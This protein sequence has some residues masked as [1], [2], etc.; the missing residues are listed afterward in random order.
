[1]SLQATWTAFKVSL[2]PYSTHI[3]QHLQRRKALREDTSL[4]DRLSQGPERGRLTAYGHIK[5]SIHQLWNV[6]LQI[7]VRCDPKS[8][9]HGIKKS[10]AQHFETIEL[11]QDQYST[12]EAPLKN[13]QL[14]GAPATGDSAESFPMF[15]ASTSSSHRDKAS[16]SLSNHFRISGSTVKSD[17]PRR[18]SGFLERTADLSE[19]SIGLSSPSQ[20]P[21]QS[22]FYGSNDFA[23][24][25]R[26]VIRI[27]RRSSQRI[28][29][30]RNV[31]HTFEE[32][33]HSIDT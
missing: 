4:Q 26:W 11:S 22:G 10:S 27:K 8:L 19:L 20:D 7:R 24:G 23:S 18:T 21:K 31:L 6:L 12:L 33:G 9:T 15:P 5:S 3:P 2:H 25:R 1:M 16:R 28:R 32:L 30:R 29:T 17:L 13:V 14:A